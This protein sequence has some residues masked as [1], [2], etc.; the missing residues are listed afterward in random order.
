MSNHYKKLKI[1]AKSANTVRSVVIPFVSYFIITK[2]GKPPVRQEWS[3]PKGPKLFSTCKSKKKKK[4]VIS[5]R[6]FTE[7]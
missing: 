6:A 3:R 7:V 2:L 4:H 1:K 5:T